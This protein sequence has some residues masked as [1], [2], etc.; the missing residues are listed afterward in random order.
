MLFEAVSVSPPSEWRLN[1][2]GLR[3][4]LFSV[5]IQR[6]LKEM[7]TH[8]GRWKFLHKLAVEAGEGSFKMSE[9]VK[10]GV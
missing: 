5:S 8:E 1:S 10:E 6:L 7:N 3:S 4:E 2:M 9:V